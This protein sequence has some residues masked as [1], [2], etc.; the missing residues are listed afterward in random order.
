MLVSY[1]VNELKEFMDEF[2]KVE[3]SLHL[4]EDLSVFW[5]D[6][7]WQTFDDTIEE[8]E[9]KIVNF[10]FSH[11]DKSVANVKLCLMPIA[12]IYYDAVAVS[13]SISADYG[14][15]FYYMESDFD[16]N[17]VFETLYED[18]D[19]DLNSVYAG[20]LQT[21]YVCPEYR[22]NGIGAFVVANL[23]R[24]LYMYFGWH[25][26]CLVSYL[27]PYHLDTKGSYAKNIAVENG[28]KLCE[29]DQKMLD[30]LKSKMQ[31]WDF[32]KIKNAEDYYIKFYEVNLD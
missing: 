11:H 7:G 30:L 5:E 12:S 25:L 16:F 31:K 23:G 13:D 24:F 18:S 21:L 17:R 3:V 19:C 8:A 29:Q 20:V 32:D 28:E 10:R 14:E 9:V 6:N 27:N 26:V 4:G 22:N 15:G 1:G 2:M